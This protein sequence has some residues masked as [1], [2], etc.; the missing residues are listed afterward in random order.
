M[1]PYRG[2][3]KVHLSAALGPVH[4]ELKARGFMAWGLGFRASRCATAGSWR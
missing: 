2:A 1:E 3:R 4:F